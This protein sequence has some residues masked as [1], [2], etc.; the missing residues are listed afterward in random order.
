MG[1]RDSRFAGMFMVVLLGLMLA[2]SPAYATLLNFDNCLDA[3]IVDSSP[4]QLQFV[5]LD[6]SVHFDQENPLH[7]LNVTVYGNVTGT[8]DRR[9]SYPSA[10]DPQ[11]SNPNDTV[12]KIVDLNTDNNKYSTLIASVNV[13]NFSPWS[14]ASRFCDSLLQGD[15]PLGP[16]FNV[17]A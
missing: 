17:N 10:D 14:D 12:G 13:V 16:V 11:W 3:S 2:V 8:A 5:P 6:V 7:A 9:S 1:L 4:Q 15:C